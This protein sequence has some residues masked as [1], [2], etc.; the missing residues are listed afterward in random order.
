MNS[1]FAARLG[2]YLKIKRYPLVNAV[3]VCKN[4]EIVFENYF[5]GFNPNSRGQIKSVWKSILSATLGVCIDKKIIDGVDETIGTYLPQFAAG[6]HPFH[7]HIT[8]RHLLTMSS[9]IYWSGGAHY[10]CPMFAR[11]FESG[12]WVSYIAD[13]NVTHYPGPFFQYKEWDVILLSA[14]IERAAGRPAYEICEEFIYAPLEIN[15]ERWTNLNGIDY[16]S[17]GEDNSS[18]LSA[19]DMA[20]I[21]SL[22]LSGGT[23]GSRRIIPEDFVRQSITPSESSDGYGFLW[24]LSGNGFGARG[25]G[26]QELNVYPELKTVAVL[27][28]T[29]T[30]RG[31]SYPDICEKLILEKDFK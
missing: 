9:G 17:P 5:N 18:D 27:Q 25:F 24:R 22:Y 2:D 20:K 3:L 1:D 14:L 30:P 13:I 31:K 11:M 6:G 15:G 16:P 4:N 7:K 8:I 26:G 29:V 21:G 12:D 19:R 28:A 23:W 10:G